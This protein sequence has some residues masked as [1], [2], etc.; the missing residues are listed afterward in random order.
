MGDIEMR[1]L[2]RGLRLASLAITL[3]GLRLCGY[4]F[5][6]SADASWPSLKDECL[7]T[8][9]EPKVAGAGLT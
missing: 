7:Y 9:H 2:W 5:T 8:G 3:R 4:P 6:V 1:N